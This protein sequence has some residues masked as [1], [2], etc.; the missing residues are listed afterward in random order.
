MV[1][2]HDLSE[3]LRSH[4]N[5][6]KRRTNFEMENYYTLHLR[7]GL[8][9]RIKAKQFTPHV[10]HLRYKLYRKRHVERYSLRRRQRHLRSAIV[11]MRIQT[12]TL[13]RDIKRIRALRLE[14]MRERV[15]LL[16]LLRSIRTTEQ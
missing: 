11:K 8:I 16:G 4:R 15:I 13:K 7:N 10:K 6:W 2:T 5:D 14:R 1:T 12:L 9:K 3:I